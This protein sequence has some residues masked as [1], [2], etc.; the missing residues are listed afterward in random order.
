MIKPIDMIP[1][2]GPTRREEKD[3]DGW[4][5]YVQ[6]PAFMAVP[7]VSVAL[8]NDQYVRY[9]SWRRGDQMI[10]DA[11]PELSIDEREKLLTGL[12]DAHFK[13]I[14]GSEGRD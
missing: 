12:D 13:R 1:G 14:L 10:Q 6:A 2:M 11:L 9:L 5:V 3:G 4:I 7:E 8:S